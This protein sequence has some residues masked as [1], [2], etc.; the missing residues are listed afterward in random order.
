MIIYNFEKYRLDNNN[1]IEGIC[2]NVT[3]SE[4]SNDF[5]V[6]CYTEVNTE[7]LSPEDAIEL[8]KEILGEEGREDVKKGFFDQP[9]IQPILL[10]EKE[11]EI[12]RQEILGD[13]RA[14]QEDLINET[15]IHE[16][17]VE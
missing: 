3:H 9:D 4:Y 14:R 2:W 10:Q 16:D 5:K 17:P 6:S 7:E 1:S 11:D 12:I 8:V 15:V 13:E